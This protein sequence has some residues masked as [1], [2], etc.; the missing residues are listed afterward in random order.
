M[1]LITKS[2]KNIVL[3]FPIYKVKKRQKVNASLLYFTS[4]FTLLMTISAT[5]LGESEFGLSTS[6]L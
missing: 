2:L 5:G 3:L 1:F 4:I 6:T